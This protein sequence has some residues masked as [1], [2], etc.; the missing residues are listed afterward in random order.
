MGWSR[1]HCFFVRTA[2]PRKSGCPSICARCP[3]RRRRPAP[4]APRR[5]RTRARWIGPWRWWAASAVA[6][7]G[8]CLYLL[9]AALH[10]LGSL[11]SLVSVIAFV[12]ITSCAFFTL[13]QYARRRPQ[14]LMDA[15]AGFRIGV[16][17]ALLMLAA[18]APAIAITGS[19]QRFGTHSLDGDDAAIAQ[20]TQA[21]QARSEQM[22]AEQGADAGQRQRLAAWIGSPEARAGCELVASAIGAGLLLL[23]AG[24]TGA[25]VGAAGA[26]RRRLV[27]GR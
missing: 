7:V 24:A 19:I 3:Q 21:L 5:R 12:W 11:S 22:M 15:R 23:Y 8:A 25:L 27:L 2:A 10:A 20:Q 26:R 9:G 17:S 18:L 13:S 4:P 14:G 16:A 6:L 1:K